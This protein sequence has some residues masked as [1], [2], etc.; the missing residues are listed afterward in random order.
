MNCKQ[1][2]LLSRD[3]DDAAIYSVI[4]C[5]KKGENVNGKSECPDPIL[6]SSSPELLSADAKSPLF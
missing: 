6:V 1:N 5:D 2:S 3:N 4:L